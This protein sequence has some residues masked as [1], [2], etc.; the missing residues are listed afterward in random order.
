MAAAILESPGSAAFRNSTPIKLFDT[1]GY[2]APTGEVIRPVGRTY[3]VSADGRFL[4]IKD[5]L[6]REE[7]SAPQSI[8]V[9]QNWVEEL[10][11]RVPRN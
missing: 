8:T 3:D 7:T 11:R 5:V 9:I 6:G 1:R 2:L 10:K 4:M